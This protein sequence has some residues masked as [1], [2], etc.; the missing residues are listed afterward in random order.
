MLKNPKVVLIYPKFL[1]QEGPSF[2]IP[3]SVL[4]LGSYIEKQGYEVV[5]LDGNVDRK[6]FDLFKKTTK[7]ALAVGISAMTDQIS[8]AR[9][10]ALFLKK[11]LGIKA[12]L[13]FGGVHATLFPEQTTFDPLVDFTVIG[14]GELSFL[15]LL[16]YLQKKKKLE[17][18][19]GVGSKINNKFL[20]NPRFIRFDFKDM[21]L[22]NYR[23][24]NPRL[25][26]EF[27]DYYIAMITS[28][29]CPHRCAFCINTVIKENTRWRA[30]QSE[31]VIKE[32]SNIVENFHVNK[33]FFWDENFFVNK[34]RVEEILTGLE[35]ENLK[36]KWFANARTD[37]FK[38]DFL[39][40]SFLKRLKA[41]GCEKFGIGAESGSQ[42]ML[43]IY[44][45]G[46]TPLD[47]INSASL[48]HQVKIIPTYSFMIGAPGETKKDM[49]KTIQ[50]IGKIY[51]ACP[52]ARILGPQLFRPYPG[53]EL[54]QKCLEAGWSEPKTLLEWE[55]VV[56]KEF[57]ET[58]PFKSPWM[59][60]PK[61]IN[62]IWFYSSLL[63][64]SPVMLIRLFIEYTKIYKKSF[65]YQV[66]GLGGVLGMSAL[67]KIRYKLHFYDYPFEVN[68][69]KKF[70][71]ILSS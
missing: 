25:L 66:F 21:P 2:N 36:I 9:R 56:E 12:P 64:L 51:T 15:D 11:D 53:S 71:S 38:S 10:I 61:L 57:M 37:Y 28:R 60:H 59:K 35:K 65:I 48:C 18:I 68:L 23:L 43:D 40:L 30:W 42:H 55:E 31:R 52:K 20:Y 47:M 54:Y 34:K 19:S 8:E 39:N 67:G 62:I 33:I 27:P 4:H 50:I 5:I 69:F 16:K 70:R 3:L 26:K 29:G 17:E 24:L 58:S 13:V 63:V 1:I 44:N 46:T 14:E 45:K 7:D 32:I 22:I 6:Y 41:N 49:E